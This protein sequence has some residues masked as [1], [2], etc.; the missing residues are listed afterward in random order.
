M[1]GKGGLWYLGEQGFRGLKITIVYTTTYKLERINMPRNYAREYANYHSKPKA[2]KA[3][4]AA[5]RARRKL[6]LKPGDPR[7]VDHKVPSSK[8]GTNARSNLRIT[9]RKA[10]RKKGAK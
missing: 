9:T 8:G 10:N 3:R 1:G 2:R 4:A 7:E 5:N 6:K